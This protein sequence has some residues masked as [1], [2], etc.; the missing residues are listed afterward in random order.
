MLNKM[1]RL[2]DNGRLGTRPLPF[3][4]DGVLPNLWQL[5]DANGIAQRFQGYFRLRYPEQRLRVTHCAVEKLYYRPERSCKA[6]YRL[7]FRDRSGQLDEQWFSVQMS[8]AEKSYTKFTR[9]QARQKT[10]VSFWEPVGFWPEIDTIIWTFPHDS[11]LKQ[12]P[13]LIQPQTMLG[14]LETH[15][16]QLP[17]VERWRY[18]RLKMMPRKRCLLEFA[19]DDGGLRLVTKSYAKKRDGRVSKGAYAHQ[20]FQDVYQA[21][22]DNEWLTVPQPFFYDKALDTYAQEA[23]VGT[24]PAPTA[25]I[26]TIEQ[27]AMALVQF[28][29]LTTLHHLQACTRTANLVARVQ[30]ETAFLTYFLPYELRIPTIANQLT[31]AAVVLARPAVWQTP[32]HGAFRLN[33]LLASNGRFALL[34][35]DDAG[36]GDPHLDV[37]ECIASQ[38]MTHFTDDEMLAELQANADVFLQTYC[39][40]AAWP[41]DSSR[42]HGFIAL[43]LFQKLAGAFRRL[44]TAVFA[45]IDSLLDLVEE[46]LGR[47]V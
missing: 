12:L 1:S 33:Q 37:A 35:L 14:L 28:H 29:Q 34:D 13:E 3:F 42:L 36:W 46:H 39:A 47:A 41:V 43:L 21:T 6:L 17:A 27:A 4:H 15:Q 10:A 19:A 2:A 31:L 16:P 32:V 9:A 26:A 8:P 7:Q 40:H 24:S 22:L 18:R 11:Q 44:E 38:L 30:S 23:C 20:I 45:K 5:A 25:P